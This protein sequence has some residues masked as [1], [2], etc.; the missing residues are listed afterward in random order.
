MVDADIEQHSSGA[1][2]TRTRDRTHGHRRLVAVLG[3]VILGG[4]TTL[5]LGLPGGAQ[6]ARAS[7][8]RSPA[9]ATARRAT[10]PVRDP[11]IP[12]PTAPAATSPATTAT[13]AS[14]PAPTTPDPVPT[15]LAAAPAPATPVVAS[16]TEPPVATLVAEV[17]ATGID[18]G[19]SW[20]W[21]MGDTATQ[22]GAI[23]GDKA[24]TGCTSGAAG[25]ATTVFAGAPS[26]ALVAHELADAE[27]ENDA[28]PSLMA[29]VT[30]AEAG[31]SWSS[32]DAVASCLVVHF[33]GFQDDAAGS[34][35]CPVALATVVAA[36]IDDA[37]TSVAETAPN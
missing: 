29:E 32:I 12:A 25:A 34:W 15:T 21:R 37:T 13:P 10:P 16:I 1:D 35:Q 28:V 11:V 33:M 4:V 2:Q 18:P 26:L 27:T 30:S 17:E 5:L 9:Q 23:P 7:T 20:N 19:P 3:A 36:D 8:T 6:P 31:T 14:I 22:C 24:G